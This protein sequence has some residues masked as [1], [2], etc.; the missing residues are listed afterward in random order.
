MENKKLPAEPTI[1]EE[2][3]IHLDIGNVGETFMNWA[4]KEWALKTLIAAGLKN[5]E[6]E[7][8]ESCPYK[9]LRDIFIDKINEFS[10][11]QTTESQTQL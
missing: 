7:G 8:G 1:Q 9:Y 3:V 2:F 11:K 5:I 4:E 10:K 6:N